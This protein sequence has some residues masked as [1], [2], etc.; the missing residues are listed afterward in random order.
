MTTF[1]KTLITYIDLTFIFDVVLLTMWC[2]L[3]AYLLSR[4]I[5]VLYQYIQQYIHVH[6]LHEYNWE[7]K[8]DPFQNNLH[9]N[10]FKSMWLATLH[11]NKIIG[12]I[13]NMYLIYVFMS[14]FM[15]PVWENSHYNSIYV[16]FNCKCHSVTH[17]NIRLHTSEWQNMYA[18]MLHGMD[19]N[20]KCS[21]IVMICHML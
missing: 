5:Y 19:I 12:K 13:K 15:S 17:T 4:F 16:K 11:V 21:L 6:V 8:I 20:S 10:I 1:F 9:S 3:A 18:T 7:V 2:A 14:W